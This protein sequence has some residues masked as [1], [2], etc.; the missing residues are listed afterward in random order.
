MYKKKAVFAYCIVHLLQSLK[1]QFG[2][3]RSEK[4]SNPACPSRNLAISKYTA[5]TGC[6]STTGR[7][8]HSLTPPC[9]S[10][11]GSAAQGLGAKPVKNRVATRSL[12]A[13]NPVHGWKD[14]WMETAAQEACAKHVKC[15]WDSYH[16]T[17]ADESQLITKLNY[18]C[19]TTIK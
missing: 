1:T 2:V 18:C 12:D 3:G 5:R 8:R 14:A 16:H 9:S 19:D 7:T 6:H 4:Q 11:D 15:P 17:S 10:M 13:G